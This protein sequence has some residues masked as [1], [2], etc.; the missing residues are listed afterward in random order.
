MKARAMK[1]LRRFLP[2]PLSIVL[3][4]GSLLQ[5][6]PAR[7][8]TASDKAAAEALFREGRRLF[9]AGSYPAAC[10]K[11]AESE[12]LD[13]APGTLLNLA[14]CY[15]KNGQT[16]SAWATFK[17]AVSAS[18]QKGRADWEELARTRAAALEPALSR[19]TISVAASSLDGLQVH[20]DGAAVGQAEWGTP[21]PVDP[22]PH[23]IDATAP[24]RT[25][26][27]QSVDVGGG[28]TNVTVSIPELAV[29]SGGGRGGEGG[30]S[31]ASAPSPGSTQRIIGLTV[32]GAGVVGIGI[33]AVFGIVAMNKENSALGSDCTADKYCN[34]QGLQL[35]QDAHSAAT[36][37]TIAFAAGAV[38]VA[39]GL[40]L[41]FLAP[42]NPAA[43]AVGLR[44]SGL[45]GGASLGLVGAW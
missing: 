4:S 6:T 15:E 44:A 16:A 42:K 11:L 38:A 18:H 7:A 21:I 20:R 26:F 30:G 1:S 13:P 17:E 31:D 9:D 32:A 3:V 14:G 35:G 45:P 25:A 27:H 2:F 19:L 39:G 5:A 33:G 29:D 28:G 8:Q 40:T 22:G 23:V 12:R 36:A 10:A 37:S 24:G 34:Q 43:P 41:Y